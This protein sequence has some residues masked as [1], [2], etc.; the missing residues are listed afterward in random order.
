[1]TNA[2]CSRRVLVVGA[3]FS[4]LGMGAALQAQG[5]EFATTS[6]ATGRG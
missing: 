3:G 6:A 5:I 2:T 4:G 1:M